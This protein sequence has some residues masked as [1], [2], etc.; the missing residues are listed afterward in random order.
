MKLSALCCE[1]Q[2]FQK[3]KKKRALYIPDMGSRRMADG[4]SEED[5]V[6]AFVWLGRLVIGLAGEEKIDTPLFS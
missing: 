4:E 5:K 1:R 3:K 2:S 6:V